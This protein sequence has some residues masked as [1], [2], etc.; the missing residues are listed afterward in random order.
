M[1]RLERNVKR[2]AM[3]VTITG[4][5]AIAAIL[6]FQLFFT[7]ESSTSAVNADYYETPRSEAN[8]SEPSQE[9]IETEVT[10]L[11]TALANLQTVAQTKRNL[12]TSDEQQAQ[13][14][15]LEEKAVQKI[16]RL[17]DATVSN[18]QRRRDEAYDVLQSYANALGREIETPTDG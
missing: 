3:P 18:F 6:V 5:L 16:E 11:N 14:E 10:A 12:D 15:D 8:E 7:D 9:M 17:S 2:I 4:A 13:F 1:N